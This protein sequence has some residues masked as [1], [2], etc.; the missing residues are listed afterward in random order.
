MTFTT[1][2]M[3]KS[4]LV[5][6]LQKS[7]PFYCIFPG[8]GS[9]VPGKSYAM[10]ASQAQPNAERSP[11]PPDRL[12]RRSVPP[13]GWIILL[14]LVLIVLA[15]LL[16]PW[17][18][19]QWMH[20]ISFAAAVA[21]VISGLVWWVRRGPASPWLRWLPAVALL[22]A[23]ISFF[24]LY[25][26][27]GVSGELIP[28]IERRFVRRPPLPTLPERPL[29]VD[30]SPTDRADGSPLGDADAVPARTEAND[31]AAAP[32]QRRLNV[33]PDDS[34]GFLGRNRD[35]QAPDRRFGVDWQQQPPQIRWRQPIGEGWSS[36]AL[37]S[38]YGVTLEQRSDAEWI[39]CYRLQDGALVWKHVEPGRHSHPLGGV[40]PRSTPTIH[41]GRVYAQTAT[42]IVVCLDGDQGRLL[43]RIDLLQRGGL[44]Q[45]TSESAVTWGR[46]GSPLIVD[47]QVVVPFGGHADA[48]DP[49]SPIASLIALDAATG[50]ELWVAGQEQIT[51]AS[52]ILT[53]LSGTRQIV[54]VNEGSMSGFQP[55]DGQA[56]WSVAWES[57]SDAGAHCATP[58]VVGNDRLLLGKGYGSGGMLTRID[59]SGSDLQAEV[60]WHVPSVLKTKFTNAVVQDGFAYA[61]SDGTLE[62]VELSSAQRQ[63]RQSRGDRYG[64]GQLLLAD[65]VLLVQCESGEVALVACDPQ[66]FRELARIEVLNDKTWN[67]PALAGRTL[68]VRNH[69]Q[70]AVIDLPPR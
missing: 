28:I 32:G 4:G 20:L 21:A 43:W 63:W 16:A 35:G 68:V 1:D 9:V 37:A 46:A 47:D 36:F 5:G 23:I 18:D 6:T 53:T 66:E 12:R 29:A 65:D 64:H 33:G 30:G 11:S 8:G 49:A 13:A 26:V 54:A 48:D 58:V 25:R 50:E 14:C 7:L 10:D 34:P 62:C 52:P 27:T 59:G 51:Y 24:S 17:T 61:L 3:T 31:S 67:Q 15:Q 55:E 38:G 70:A 39:T 42:G 40:G 2:G 60:V 45:A 22:L 44:D 41:Q 19:Y 69:R 56:L 57:S